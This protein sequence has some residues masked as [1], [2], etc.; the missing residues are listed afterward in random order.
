MRGEG[1]GRRWRPRR[2]WLENEHCL[3]THQQPLSALPYLGDV[4]VGGAVFT[5]LLNEKFLGKLSLSGAWRL[6]Q[7]RVPGTVVPQTPMCHVTVSGTQIEMDDRSMD[8]IVKL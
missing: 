1:E 5:G 4:I 7:C 8:R 3:V 6:H 2:W